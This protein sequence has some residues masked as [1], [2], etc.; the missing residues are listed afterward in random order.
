MGA[1]VVRLEDERRL[2]IYRRT[3][4]FADGVAGIERGAYFAVAN[5]SKRSVFAADGVVGDVDFEEVRHA[6]AAITPVPGG[7]GPVTTMMLLAQTMDAAE[8]L[9]QA[10]AADE[11]LSRYDLPAS[12]EVV[13]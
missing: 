13:G 5:F 9:A 1:D 10:S 7:V 12:R 4:P 11:A 6:A 8:R 3:G 2:D